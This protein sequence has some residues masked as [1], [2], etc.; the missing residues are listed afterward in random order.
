MAKD[1]R[2]V[3]IKLADR[4]HNMRTLKFKEE[5]KS[6]ATAQETLEVYAPLAHR[7]GIYAIK[8]E[9]EDLS[10]RYMEPQKYYELVDMVAQKRK[11]REQI[12][13]KIMTEIKERL[14]ELGIKGQIMGRPKH[15]FSIYNKMTTKNLSFDQ[16][17]DLI[18]VRII[19]EDV[20]DCYTLLGE[21]HMRWRPIPG[22]F[23]DYISLPKPNQYQSLH[24]TVLGPQGLPFEVQIRTLE[25]HRVAEYG[26]AAHWT[27]K[28]GTKSGGTLDNKLSWIRQMMD[29]QDENE[30]ANDFLDSVKED[31]FSE[32]VF[33]FT[34]KGDVINLPNGST[35]LD[36]AYRIHSAVGNRCVGAK[37]NQKIVTLDTELKTGDIVQIVTSASSKGPS[38]DW[39]KIVK[40]SEAK[41]KIRQA[42]KNSLRDENI[43]TG[44]DMLE[45]E[46]KRQGYD[47]SKLLKQESMEKILQ[48]VS[49]K[50][51]EDM[52]STVGFGGITAS[53]LVTRLANEYRKTQKV[54][55]KENSDFFERPVEKVEGKTSEHGVFVRG[56]GNMLVRFA[57][58][59]N[60][61]PGDDIVGYITRGRGVSI[62]RKDCNNLMSIEGDE[63]VRLVDVAW[64]RESLSS[65]HAGVLVIAYEREG[66]LSNLMNFLQQM[67]IKVIGMHA[68]PSKDRTYTI[69][70]TIEI[71]DIKQLDTII[72]RLQRN[73]DII[74][75]YR[76][77]AK[78]EGIGSCASSCS[79][80]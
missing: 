29:L 26:V 47:L 59:C 79:A 80:C 49:L 12:I 21:V 70:F 64:D 39:L 8:W 1:L 73:N 3:I 38:M 9:L 58:C 34:P 15:L 78:R 13:E 18:A 60:P 74:E 35:P 63:A 17:Y 23:K 56:E 52:Y 45:R 76:R 50:S 67:D 20:K 57:R 31:L 54:E 44:R 30:D 43:L 42:L 19:V 72:G 27:Y 25:M 2:V 51:I 55:E 16:I 62:H 28:E 4:L 14:V 37:V 71:H 48:K 32:E 6:H 24:T 41:S 75:V 22:R 11:E 77:S 7:L 61:V 69:N 66:V 40:T 68:M 65:Y 36:F 46:A 10:F 5:Q 53:Q 33:V